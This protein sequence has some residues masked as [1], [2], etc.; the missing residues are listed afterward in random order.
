MAARIRVHVTDIPLSMR[1]LTYLIILSGYFFYCYNFLLPGYIRPYLISVFGQTL[2]ETAGITAAQNVGVTIG[3]LVAASVIARMGRR[4]TAAVIAVGSGLL[5]LACLVAT[6]GWA[7]ILLRAGV[8]FFLGGYYVAAVTMTVSLF[9]QAYRA[10]LQALNSGMFSLAE[11]VLGALGALFGD[12]GWLLLIVV[13]GVP[14]LMVA[15][16]IRMV[17]PDDRAMIGYGEERDEGAPAEPT[18]SWAEMLSARWRRYTLSCV[19]MAGT[20][21]TGYQLFSEFVTLYLRQER[22]FGA[23]EIGLAFSLIG[24]GSLTG[25]FF[26]AWISDRFGRRTPSIGFF[27]AALSI[28]GFLAIPHLPGLI[29]TLGFVYGFCLSCTYPWGIWFTEIFP[30]RLRSYAAALLHGGHILSIVAPLIIAVIANRYGIAA[31]MATAPL[32]FIA[33]ALIWRTLPE[34]VGRGSTVAS[35]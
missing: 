6:S 9:P 29:K 8:A 26:W 35:Q 24:V 10:R 17:V 30:T 31:G 11:I 14:P 34:T 28:I 5:T 21:F 16:L 1:V 12:P 2:G 32:M 19:I 22:G 27:G 15:V 18:G 33:G 25:G 7:W 3:S 4:W 23:G 13:G 20:N